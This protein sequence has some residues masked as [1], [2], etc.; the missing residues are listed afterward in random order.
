MSAF[1]RT[2][3]DLRTLRGIQRHAAYRCGHFAV[4]QM[5]QENGLYGWEWCITHV[6]SGVGFATYFPSRDAA[7][8][9]ALEITPLR[10]DWARF[11]PR[12]VT[13]KFVAGL[14]AI[15]ARHG[16]MLGSRE[17]HSLTGERGRREYAAD[18]NGYGGDAP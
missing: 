18:L 2:S 10:D 1:E 5:L 14:R 13:P 12:T 3:I 11:D 6:P 7:Q 15:F 17:T 16:G 4:H 8:A 9:A